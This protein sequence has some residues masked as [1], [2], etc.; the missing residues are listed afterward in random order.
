MASARALARNGA[1][2]EIV[3]RAHISRSVT[4]APRRSST[5]PAIAGGAIALAVVVALGVF[6]AGTDHLYA[7]G[8]AHG[9]PWDAVIGNVNFT[10][11]KA[12]E[13]AIV[14]DRRV[15]AATP[16]RYGQVTVG[17]R[18]TEVLAYDPAGTAPPEMLQGRAPTHADEIAPGARLL[19]ELARPPRRPGELSSPTASSRRRRAAIPSTGAHGT[20]AS[21]CHR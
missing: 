8:G 13:S 16:A 19:H 4:K 2:A 20:S 6:L 14:H 3:D 15:A 7:N 12:R 9:W 5:R 11:S 17:G 10:M 21:R 18:S 1:P